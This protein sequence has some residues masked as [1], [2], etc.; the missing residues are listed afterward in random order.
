MMTVITL[1]YIS[2]LYRFLLRIVLITTTSY[3][4]P[5]PVIDILINE[6]TNA[7]NVFLFTA[8]KETPVPSQG[9]TR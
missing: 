1:I 7:I 3:R 2:M 6:F 4:Y 8:K 5:I 9:A